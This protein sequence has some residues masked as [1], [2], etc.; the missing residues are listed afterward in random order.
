MTHATGSRLDRSLRVFGDVRQGEGRTVVLLFANIFL[1]LAA[2]YILKVVR[3]PLVLATGGAELKAYAAAT[4]AVVLVIVV[5][6]YAWLASRTDRIRLIVTVLVAH[7]ACIELF[8]LLGT[9][10]V[11]MVGFAFY[12][13][14][15]VFSSMA[16]AQFWSL[17]NDIFTKD[18]GERLFPLVAVG[19]TAGAPVGAWLASQLF[20]LQI[21]PYL[22]MQ[23]AV[24]V[25]IVHGLV[26][27]PLAGRRR[28]GAASR[29]SPAAGPHLGR[30]G[31]F[32][33][34]F[35]SPYLR[36]MTLMLVLLNVVNT[37][38]EYILSR[39]IVAAADY[40]LAANLIADKESFIGATYGS[41]NVGVSVFAVLV[42][43]LLSSRLVKRFGIAGVLFPL[44]FI[45]LGGYSM[46]AAG[47]TAVAIGWIKLAEN[48]ADY[49][50]MNTA[51]HM[52][53]LPT[54]REEKYKAKQAIDGF[55][56]RMGD[57]LAGAVV[58]AGSLVGLTVSGFATLNILLAAG[59]IGIV[60]LLY[61]CYRAYS[62]EDRTAPA[63]VQ[64]AVSRS[65]PV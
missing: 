24:A 7:V 42:Q 61:R 11:P 34:V 30:H 5:P 37:V 55:F 20:S 26:Y 13:W 48:A 53:W 51:K 6:L 39:T 23:V 52:L 18:E 45:S 8:F 50:V 36:L 32:S 35:S 10:G 31:A 38:G 58:F 43:A 65:Q 14:L 22:L 28:T 59:W 15:G 4:Q 44:P 54:S 25:L 3:E 49:S 46:V 12:V 33:L 64:A 60:W 19:S 41:F 21:S 1:L 47:A 9:A 57:L 56:V 62:T 63:P 16:V 17:A 29:T 40:R 27:Q 2:Y